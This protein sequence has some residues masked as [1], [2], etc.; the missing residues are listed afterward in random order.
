MIYRNNNVEKEQ[1]KKTL[2][3]ALFECCSIVQ[4][5]LAMPVQKYVIPSG[6]LLARKTSWHKKKG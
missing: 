1:R 5:Y 3:N 4:S 6:N 2:V